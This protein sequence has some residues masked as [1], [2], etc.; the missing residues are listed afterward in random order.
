MTLSSLGREQ[1]ASLTV[2]GGQKR[3]VT[4]VSRESSKERVGQSSQGTR[5]DHI[6]TRSGGAVTPINSTKHQW[7]RHS[8]G[9]QAQILRCSNQGEPTTLE[10]HS[11]IAIMVARAERNHQKKGKHGVHGCV[12]QQVPKPRGGGSRTLA[13]FSA[14]PH[15]QPHATIRIKA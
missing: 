15:A 10:T 2:V 7:R 6:S 1:E 14:R 5:I 8:S 12:R 13:L 11:M 9:A 4:T 3:E